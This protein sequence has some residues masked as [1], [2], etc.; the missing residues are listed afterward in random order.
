MRQISLGARVLFGRILL[1]FAITCGTTQI[2]AAATVTINVFEQGGD[3]V[4][5]YSGS[6][7]LAGLEAIPAVSEPFISPSS[8]AA[9]SAIQN[10]VL[11]SL[12]IQRGPD[13]LATPMDTRFGTGNL[14]LNPSSG[15]SRSGDF[16]F[17]DP[18]SVGVAS[19]YTSGSA[20]AGQLRVASRTIESLMLFD[21]TFTVDLAGN[22][23]A[24]F[25]VGVTAVPLPASL[26]FL[27]A[28][29]GCLTLVGRRKAGIVQS[30]G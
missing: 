19:D 23:S 30:A 11:F 7:D 16:Y 9:F 29:I 8:G 27:L 28:G 15:V 1:M 3:T 26:V 18:F 2:A 4:F 25:N 22:N 5:D 14:L 13:G 24:I 20:L 10:S 21:G 17:F 12:Y 6:V